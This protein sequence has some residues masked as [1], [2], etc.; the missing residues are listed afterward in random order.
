MKGEE[1]IYLF[2]SALIIKKSAKQKATRR[3]T[4]CLPTR[5][6][7]REFNSESLLTYL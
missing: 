2:D 5:K 1:E 7:K 4:F 3:W 6:G